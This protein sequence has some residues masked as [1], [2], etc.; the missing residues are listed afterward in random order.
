M[1]TTQPTLPTKEHYIEILEQVTLDDNEKLMLRALYH[2]KGHWLTGT[3]LSQA[4][5]YKIA[6]TSA[7]RAFGRLGRKI[8]EKLGYTE[9]QTTAVKGKII[10]DYPTRKIDGKD[11]RVYAMHPVVV[12][13]L[14]ELRWFE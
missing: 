5:G 10:A 14:R 12:E 1:T 8:C 6:S 11:R 13:A 9:K 7:N 2:A 3:E 4:A